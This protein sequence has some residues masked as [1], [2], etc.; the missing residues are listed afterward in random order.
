MQMPPIQGDPVT[1][2]KAPTTPPTDTTK[3]VTP[4][5]IM[6]AGP[7][8]LIVIR[9]DNTDSKPE[10]FISVKRT[11]TNPGDD[12]S[13]IPLIEVPALQR[14]LEEA[15]TPALGLRSLLPPPPV[16]STK[17]KKGNRK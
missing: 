5:S 2:E 3:S 7:L 16:V 10:F 13:M 6:S 11:P 4:V 14:M 9:R 15:F 12:P 1:D 8:N 17:R